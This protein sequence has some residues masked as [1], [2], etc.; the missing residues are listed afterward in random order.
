MRRLQRLPQA[1]ATPAASAVLA[2][3]A[4]PTAPAATAAPAALS[5]R[6]DNSIGRPG[7]ACQK[8][9]MSKAAGPGCLKV[10]TVAILVHHPKQLVVE[11]G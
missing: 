10:A 11:G 7:R 9:K 1:P 5:H 8:Y 2:A 6:R 3:P 4:V